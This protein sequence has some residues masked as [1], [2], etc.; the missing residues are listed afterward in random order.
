MDDE[1]T[2][3]DLDW[4]RGHHSGPAYPRWI[5]PGIGP[6]GEDFEALAVWAHGRGG[7]TPGGKR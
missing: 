3:R 1:V 7:A 5:H 2:R 4:V 6:T